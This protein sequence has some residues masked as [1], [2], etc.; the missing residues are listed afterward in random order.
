MIKIMIISTD[1]LTD[2]MVNKLREMKS[3]GLE[4]TFHMGKVDSDLRA[5]TIRRMIA[6]RKSKRFMFDRNYLNNMS[7]KFSE[8]K[9]FSGG[10]YKFV[11]HLYRS[12]KDIAIKANEIE[13][14]HE[15]YDYFYLAFDFIAGIFDEYKI[16]HVLF[17]NAPH[18]GYDTICYEVARFLGVKTTIL[19]QSIFP[20]KFFS[21]SSV[22]L[23][24]D[25]KIEENSNEVYKI[26]KNVLPKLFYMKGIDSNTTTATGI[27]ALGVL[28]VLLYVVLREPILLVRLDKLMKILLRV[29]SVYRRTPKW[30][31]PFAKFFNK[32]S[33]EYFEFIVG[34]QS[35]EVDFNC[36]YVYFPLHLQPEMTTS[37]LGGP[38]VDQ[39][40]AIEMLSSM[41]PEDIKI[42]VKE[43]PKQMG[44]MRGP[45]FF[46]RIGRLKNVQVIPEKINSHALIRNCIFVATI[47]G[48]AGWEALQVGKPALIFGKAWYSS[49]PGAVKYTDGLTFDE[50]VAK[51]VSH[52]HE[53]LERAVGQLL[54]RMHEGVLDR[55]YKGLVPDYNNED[56][57]LR[58]AETIAKLISN[59]KT[60]TFK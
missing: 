6:K 53:S 50:I 60:Y 49:L 3:S 47:T 5:S 36:K 8:D 31:D 33:L 46:H 13:Y 38:F 27:S 16:E 14:I 59:K 15:A 35:V 23:F 24:G 51:Q 17:F 42:Y 19:N 55:H 44:F 21:T 20:G 39:A 22:D 25:F 30:R 29:N 32:R 41:L 34:L 52:D 48:T 40:L 56:N 4:V 12:N 54:S 57:A 7:L 28:S 18:L 10:L 43:N 26:N 58:V 37:A 9:N 1:K 45:T 2:L 11:D